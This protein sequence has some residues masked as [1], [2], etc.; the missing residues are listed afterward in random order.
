MT[1]FLDNYRGFKNQY[2]TLKTVNFF[3]GE[4]STGKTSLISALTIL[5]D[6]RF[7]LSGEITSEQIEY[8]SFEDLYSANPTRDYFSL[9]LIDYDGDKSI[10]VLCFKD[11][12][13]FPIIF[14]EIVYTF[15]G[16]MIV[17]ERGTDAVNYL[18]I[19]VNTL[20]DKEKPLE[21]ILSYIDSKD[22]R[23][24]KMQSIKLGNLRGQRIP[25][26][27][28]RQ[29]ID[30]NDKEVHKKFEKIRNYSSFYSINLSY[31]APIRAK[32]LPLYSGGKQAFSPE[33]SHAPFILKEIISAKKDESEILK[34]LNEYGQESGLFDSISA[35]TYGDKKISP[36]ELAIEK[37]KTKY[38]ISS[39]GYGVSQI[40]PI[41][42]ELLLNQSS[43]MITIQQPE[44]HLHPK[45]QAS[46]G[47]F[48]YKIALKFKKRKFVVETHSDYV[49]DRFRYQLKVETTKIDS[50][51]LF[52]KNNGKNNIVNAISINTDG[53]YNEN[54]IDEFRS[55]FIN[56]SFK[57]MEI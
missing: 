47:A 24:L 13:G 28:Y 36:F 38:K 31:L 53:K 49:I 42:T 4:N 46:F 41:I 45:A 5:S 25:F 23:K 12:D 27:A 18:T 19:K 1:Y 30:A 11:D 54:E 2:I 40:L 9:G 44:V 7:W 26:S 35:T 51:I 57:V 56:E 16:D 50:Q 22:F 37:N 14:R 34:M 48:L 8:K 20:K 29:V 6:F 55:F 21:E 10:H 15:Q 32:P 3:V 33:G 43:Q 39:V 52:F 17:I